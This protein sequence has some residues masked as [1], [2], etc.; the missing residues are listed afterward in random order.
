MSANLR[1]L[2][3]TCGQLGVTQ[4]PYTAH[5]R[6]RREPVDLAEDVEVKLLEEAAELLGY[7]TNAWKAALSAC[8]AWVKHHRDEDDNQALTDILAS[9]E[10]KAHSF[11]TYR[12]PT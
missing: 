7:G 2:R 6:K 9:S 1:A 8:G 12:C 5:G 10:K 11:S 3:K 4:K